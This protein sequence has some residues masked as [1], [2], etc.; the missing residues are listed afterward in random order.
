MGDGSI[1][2]DGCGSGDVVAWGVGCGV[3][4]DCVG[5]SLG[6][7]GDSVGSGS[8]DCDG[9]L[10]VGVSDG[11]GSGVGCGWIGSGVGNGS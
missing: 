1:I 5:G 8:G 4:T 10:A 2:G 6:T 11:V 7:M 3:T 9:E